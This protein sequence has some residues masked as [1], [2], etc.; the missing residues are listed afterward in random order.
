MPRISC[1]CWS[2]KGKTTLFGPT[3]TQDPAVFSVFPRFFSFFSQLSQFLPDYFGPKLFWPEAY[4]AQTFSNRAY[5]ETCVSSELLRACYSCSIQSRNIH[6][7]CMPTQLGQSSI[8]CLG[9]WICSSRPKEVVMQ[10]MMHNSVSS[11]KSSFEHCECRVRNS[12]VETCVRSSRHYCRIVIEALSSG[13]PFWW[14]V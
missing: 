3:C 6:I 11:F 5:A 10:P 14:A 2:Q 8:I 1:H 9:K 13:E 12:Y 7:W 4:P